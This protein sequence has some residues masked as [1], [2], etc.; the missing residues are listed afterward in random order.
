MRKWADFSKPECAID[1]KI[2]LKAAEKLRHDQY[3]ILT[4]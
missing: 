4:I 1:H 3:E 2:I